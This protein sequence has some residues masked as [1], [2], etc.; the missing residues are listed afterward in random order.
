MSSKQAQAG[1]ALPFHRLIPVRAF[2]PRRAV[3]RQREERPDV[4]SM[5]H[6][7]RT[8]HPR[9]GTLRERDA[10]QVAN[11]RS[12]C[13]GK[14]YSTT[15]TISNASGKPVWILVDDLVRQQPST[16]LPLCGLEHALRYP[17]VSTRIT[18]VPGFWPCVLSA[19]GF[20]GNDRAVDV[21]HASGF[22]WAGRGL[23]RPFSRDARSS[24]A[25]ATAG[26]CSARPGPGTQSLIPA[27][28]VTRPI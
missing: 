5:N 6:S 24:P 17:R 19:P 15:V 7:A 13:S 3:S 1:R 23:F 4:R 14:P 9:E 27:A 28:P 18:C 8:R 10:E 21:D 25:K 12:V 22:L 16:R 2:D 20:A 26:P 11:Q